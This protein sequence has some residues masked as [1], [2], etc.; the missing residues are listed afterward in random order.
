[1]RLF[2]FLLVVVFALALSAGTNVMGQCV[3][4]ISI[5][6]VGYF[7]SDDSLAIFAREGD[8]IYYVV[9][10]ELASGDCPIEDGE[11]TLLLP[12]GSLLDLDDNL[13][14]AAGNQKVYTVAT[15]YTVD[16]A[17]KG[18]DG[19]PANAVRATAAIMATAQVP[20]TPGL[21]VTGSGTWD[22][23]V[24]DPDTAVTIDA[25]VEYVSPTGT[26]VTLTITEENTGDVDLTDPYIEVF[27]GGLSIGTFDETSPEFQGGDD[28]DGILNAGTPGETWG[29]EIVV[30]GVDADTTFAAI[31]HGT[32]PLGD[33]TT[34]CDDP[35]SP[36]ADTF[37]DQDERDEV[38]VTVVNPDTQV[39]ISASPLTV[40]ESGTDVTLTITEENT[41][42]VDLTDPYIEVFAGAVS[43]G[44]F[45][46]TSPEF[47]GGDDGDG[48][49]NAGTPGETWEWQIVVPGV[50]ADT[51]FAAIGHGEDPFGNDVTWCEE[52]GSPPADTICDQDERDEV[53]VT[54]RGDTFCSFTQGFWGNA[55]GMKW[56]YTT[57]ELINMALDGG[58]ITIGVGNRSI[59]FN[60]ASCIIGRLPAGG[61]AKAIPSKSGG[62]NCGNLSSFP[63]NMRHKDGRFKNVLIGQVVALSLNVA[64]DTSA[65]N[66]Y[67]ELEDFELSAEFCVQPEEEGACPTK[68][69]IP[70]AVLTALGDDNTVADLLAL[71]NQ[72]LGGSHPE[73]LGPITDAVTAVNEAFDE[74]GQYIACPETETIC[75]DNCDNDFDGLF[76]G[77]DP[78]CQ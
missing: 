39:T 7:D 35:G 25:D 40:I 66:D 77:D 37:C 58:M 59:T 76:D 6:P 3:P 64:L 55:G 73:L 18:N 22:I 9:T 43:L 14:L 51:T 44:T 60:S 70:G 53:T 11:P 16:P 30:S 27:V 32:D 67:G 31:G 21:P 56:G 19:A 78:D 45:D 38:S 71:A 23:V 29:W 50:D 26:D 17:H 65:F 72:V 24:I 68:W 33:D 63:N 36:P 75:D 48:I 8:V 34:W 15:T 4:K 74:C 49:L 46:E 54:L 57:T 5:G 47:Q 20:G 12:N 62:W 42:D 52:P 61:P 13:S 1:M 41:G 10:V 2:K 28:G 69:T